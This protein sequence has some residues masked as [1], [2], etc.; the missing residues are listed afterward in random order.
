LFFFAFSS[1]LITHSL[2]LTILFIASSV[3][4]SQTSIFGCNHPSCQHL[5][6]IALNRKKMKIHDSIYDWILNI[7]NT[8]YYKMF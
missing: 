1:L 5:W 2:L 6:A 7:T 4:D 3:K 8:Y